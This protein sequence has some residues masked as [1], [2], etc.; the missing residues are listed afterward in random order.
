MKFHHDWCSDSDLS[1]I[2]YDTR[3]YMGNNTQ[4]KLTNFIKLFNAPKIVFI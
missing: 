4:N 1:E 3:E 2:F